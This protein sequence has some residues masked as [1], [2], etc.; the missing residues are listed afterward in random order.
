MSIFLL[1]T[2][3]NEHTII[4]YMIG[5]RYARSSAMNSFLNVPPGPLIGDAPP[6][7]V[8]LHLMLTRAYF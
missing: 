3:V 4:R 8:A 1:S 6:L 5:Y 2:R 7:V